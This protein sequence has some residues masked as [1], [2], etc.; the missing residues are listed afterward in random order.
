M[1][2]TIVKFIILI[3]IV[4]KN[5]LTELKVR[6]FVKKIK[7]YCFYQ[8]TYMTLNTTCVGSQRLQWNGY[9]YYKEK[10]FN[11]IWFKRTCKRANY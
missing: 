3:N 1:N 6:Y 5:E 10:S 2:S 7:L 9:H 8:S 11:K 4:F